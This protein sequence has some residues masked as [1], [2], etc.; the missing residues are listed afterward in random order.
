M[1]SDD[2]QTVEE[3]S[4][5]RLNRASDEG[6]YELPAFVWKKRAMLAMVMVTMGW[7]QCRDCVLCKVVVD[8]GSV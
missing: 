3:S 2:L 4:F 1:A 5:L 6:K 8:F 7:A